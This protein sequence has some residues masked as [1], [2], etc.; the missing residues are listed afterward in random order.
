MKSCST[1]AS[2]LALVILISLPAVVLCKEV[3]YKST[4]EGRAGCCVGEDAKRFDDID[5]DSFVSLMGRRSAAQ[6]N[7]HKNTGMMRKRPFL[8]D[9]VLADLFGQ[10]KRTGTGVL[11]P[12]P[13]EYKRKAD[14]STMGGRDFNTFCKDATRPARPQHR[15]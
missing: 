13:E 14:L 1:L 12:C 11:F 7:S 3:N 2:M 15:L 6:P 9:H 10:K 4:K 8:Q 5:Y